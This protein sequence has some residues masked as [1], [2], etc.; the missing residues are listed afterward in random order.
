MKKVIIFLIGV[1]CFLIV[2]AQEKEAEI[3][4]L[5]KNY[6]N[7][8]IAKKCESSVEIKRGESCGKGGFIPYFK[9]I[10]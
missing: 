7:I 6:F 5:L 8:I 9:F 10:R 4:V 3:N 1:S 2:D